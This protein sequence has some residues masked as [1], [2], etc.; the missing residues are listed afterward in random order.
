MNRGRKHWGGE[1]EGG[2]ELADISA[3][4]IWRWA[5]DMYRYIHPSCTWPILSNFF[6]Y[7]FNW[8][9]GGR[10]EQIRSEA[11]LSC[12]FYFFKLDGPEKWILSSLLA[13]A[14]E[15]R[16]L[17]CLRIFFPVVQSIQLIKECAFA[18]THFARRYIETEKTQDGIK[19]LF[20]KIYAP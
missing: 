2:G 15:Y 6:F 12:K 9:E 3:A 10:G 1:R 8:R 20:T 14:E 13:H 17:P 18:S 4:E 7:P 5:R 19:R 11:R 16:N